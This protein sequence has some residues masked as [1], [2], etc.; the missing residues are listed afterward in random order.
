MVNEG[1]DAQDRQGYSFDWCHRIT[2]VVL[3]AD[4]SRSIVHVVR[5]TVSVNDLE[6]SNIVLSELDVGG[7]VHPPAVGSA[8]QIELAWLRLNPADLSEDARHLHVSPLP[9]EADI[10]RNIRH[11]EP[12]PDVLQLNKVTVL[13]LVGS[14]ARALRC[15][16]DLGPFT[17]ERHPSH[18]NI[19]VENHAA[20][21]PI[22][23]RVREDVDV[24]KRTPCLSRT[25]GSQ[26]A[27]GL[28][29]PE[30]SLSCIDASSK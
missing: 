17:P 25:E 27:I 2:R 20:R 21:S 6:F 22:F 13:A 4:V 9:Y 3:D 11:I 10:S 7:Q 24:H 29:Q 19:A 8:T 1:N 18:L 14:G 15:D 30:S 26:L 5:D 23:K 28:S 16:R 12:G